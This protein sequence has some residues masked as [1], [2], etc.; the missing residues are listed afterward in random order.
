M[1][2]IICIL[3]VRHVCVARHIVLGFL[4][5]IVALCVPLVLPMINIEGA[6]LV[7]HVCV[8]HLIVVAICIPMALPIKI[9]IVIFLVGHVCIVLLIVLGFLLGIITIC[10]P[11]LLVCAIAIVA[12]A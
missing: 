7:G 4:M 10:I 1:R 8:V 2:I 5:R 9:I 11:V 6:F 12:S 3:P